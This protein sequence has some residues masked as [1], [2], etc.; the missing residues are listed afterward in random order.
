MSA[1]E[2][3][4]LAAVTHRERTLPSILQ[5]KK[6]LSWSGTKNLYIQESHLQLS[7]SSFYSKRSDYP[8]VSDNAIEKDQVNSF[9]HEKALPMKATTMRVSD[10]NL[11]TSSVYLLLK[12]IQT[13]NPGR[14]IVSAC[15]CPTVHISEFLEAVFQRMVIKCHRSSRTPTTSAVYLIQTSPKPTLPHFYF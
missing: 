14:P 8:T 9:I 6:K 1:G 12:N 4:A 3:R 5:T 11:G 2:W 13:H 15:S 7:E 10:S